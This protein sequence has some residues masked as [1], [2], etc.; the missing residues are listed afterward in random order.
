MK[1]WLLIISLHALEW[2]LRVLFK[3]YY[4]YRKRKRFVIFGVLVMH[5]YIRVN[6]TLTLGPKAL[7]STHV[8]SNDKPSCR[9]SDNITAST[10]HFNRMHLELV[11]CAWRFLKRQRWSWCYGSLLIGSMPSS[12][13]TC[14]DRE[15]INQNRRAHILYNV[16]IQ[17]YSLEHLLSNSH[18][19]RL[20]NCLLHS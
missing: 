14:S 11:V 10:E 4:L 5:W 18:M 16:C 12:V 2:L 15:F 6:F 9:K 17:Q 7:L 1:F 8:K 20:K 13:I 3:T 19:I